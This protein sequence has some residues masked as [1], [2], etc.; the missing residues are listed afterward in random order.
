MSAS[1]AQRILESAPATALPGAWKLAGGRAIT[2][3]PA[4]DGIVRVAQGRVWAT[5][6]G[7]HGRRPDDSGDHVLEAGRSL[8]VRAGQGVVLEAWNAGGAASSCFA[9]D[10]VLASGAGQRPLNVTVVLQPL[11]DLRAAAGLALRASGQLGAGLARLA[12]DALHV[13]GRAQGARRPHGAAG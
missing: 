11:A 6:D 2:L 12:W 13:G 10:P 1:S 4:T 8:F 5:V 3:R 9:W 7:P